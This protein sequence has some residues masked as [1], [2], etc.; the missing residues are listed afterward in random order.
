MARFPTWVNLS[1]LQRTSRSL[2][3]LLARYNY[4]TIL[5][6]TDLAS[7]PL[8]Q[9]FGAA[10]TKGL[11]QEGIYTVTSWQMT[12]GARNLTETRQLLAGIREQTRCNYTF[13][14]NDRLSL[15]TY[16]S[17]STRSYGLIAA[18][19]VVTFTICIKCSYRKTDL[20][21]VIYFFGRFLCT[22]S[23]AGEIVFCLYSGP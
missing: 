14:I 11:R 12:S 18:K 4:T 16:H 7:P 15:S 8:N 23:V 13:S 3:A 22:A 2:F 20:I 1:P 19:N 17:L 10:I 6:L 5:V 21:T 9:A